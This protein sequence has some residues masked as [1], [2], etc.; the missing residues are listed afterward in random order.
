MAVEY[1]DNY[2]F[3]EIDDEP[4]ERA[5]LNTSSV[6]VSVQSVSVAS[7]LSGSCQQR[8]SA[9]VARVTRAIAIHAAQHDD[10]RD[11]GDPRPARFARPEEE[12]HHKRFTRLIAQ[13]P[14]S[15]KDTKE[16]VGSGVRC[17][18]RLGG[19]VRRSSIARRMTSE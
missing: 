1:E 10:P 17:D 16:E 11:P 9:L 18:D 2:G 14:P 8:S 15:K 7:V 6:K 19:S 5:F 3:W 4:W 12:A 13:L